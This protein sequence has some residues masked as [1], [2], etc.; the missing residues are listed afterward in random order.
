MDVDDHIEWTLIDW[1]DALPDA[2][3]RSV[4]EMKLRKLNPEIILGADLVSETRHGP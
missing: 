3:N 4:L 2:E 1:L